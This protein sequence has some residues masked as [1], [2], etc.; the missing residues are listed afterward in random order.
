[1][2]G[3]L[4]LRTFGAEAHF[5]EKLNQAADDLVD[6][7]QKRTRISNTALIIRKILQWLPNII[8]AI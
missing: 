3:I 7:E 8:C 2:S 6:N 1:M 4:V 5:Q